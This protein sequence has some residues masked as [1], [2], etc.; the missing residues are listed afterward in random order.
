MNKKIL[1]VEDEKTV[2]KALVEKFT[3]E[4]FDTLSAENGEDGLSLALEKKPDLILLDLIMPKM[5][6]IQMMRR[7]RE[8]PGYGEKVPII[9]LTNL[10][11]NDRITLEA[12]KDEPSYYLVKADWKIN[13][14]VQKVKETL[15][16]LPAGE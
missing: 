6:G 16:L 11:A 12:A 10:S 14:V 9:I 1:V 3:G 4:G 5:T 8:S 15:G 2:L 7:L 13:D